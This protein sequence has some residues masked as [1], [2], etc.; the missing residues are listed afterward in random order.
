MRRRRRCWVTPWLQGE[1]K[2]KS[3]LAPGPA[4][5]SKVQREEA[6]GSQAQQALGM[7]DGGSRPD[8]RVAEMKSYYYFCEEASGCS[9]RPRVR[10][11]AEGER[12][13]R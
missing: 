9:R 2:V 4:V 6:D 11:T 1:V 12:T 8:L 3:Q 7:G 5:G 10:P 13:A